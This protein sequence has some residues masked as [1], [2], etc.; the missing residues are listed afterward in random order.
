M[1]IELKHWS[2][3]LGGKYNT[4]WKE[5]SF[6]TISQTKD[7]SIFKNK[8]QQLTSIDIKGGD[9]QQM[10]ETIKFLFIALM[11]KTL[12]KLGLIGDRSSRLIQPDT[13][14]GP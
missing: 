3:I 2:K 9:V 7:G 13:K 5:Y 12:W 11:F 10:L 6:L 1:K 14:K 4:I 8:S